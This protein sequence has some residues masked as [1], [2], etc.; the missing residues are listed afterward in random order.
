MTAHRVIW[1]VT[2]GVLAVAAIVLGARQAVAPAS[3]GRGPL[4]LGSVRA[5]LHPCYDR[6]RD[7]RKEF[8]RT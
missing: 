1:T 8:Q 4:R 5:F 6:N 2:E 7:E 3:A